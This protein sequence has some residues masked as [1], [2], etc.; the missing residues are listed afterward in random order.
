MAQSSVGLRAYS[1]AEH[2]AYFST[3]DIRPAAITTKLEQRSADAYDFAAHANPSTT[4]RHY[5]RR[6]VKRAAATE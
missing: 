5:D 1:I 6:K 4:H 2:E 3:L